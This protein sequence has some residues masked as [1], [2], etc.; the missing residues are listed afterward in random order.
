MIRQI[1]KS[2]IRNDRAGLGHFGAP[3]GDR[4]HRGVDYRVTPGSEVL[5]PVGG[6]V[7]R[8]GYAYDD[9]HSY[10]IVD[11]ETPDGYLH[12]VFYVHP[13]VDTGQEVTRF[14][15]IG[16]ALDVSRYYRPDSAMQP[17]VHYEVI[18]AG[19]VHVDPERYR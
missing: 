16:I 12:R 8:I 7:G 14:T 18:N 15:P 9:D 6:T 17:H 19:G 4:R 2:D 13:L 3:R 1:V 11:I 5:S 10:R